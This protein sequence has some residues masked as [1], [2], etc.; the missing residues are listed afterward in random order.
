MPHIR[1]YHDTTDRSQVIRLWRELLG[2][3]VPHRQPELSIDNKLACA[4]GLFFVAEAQGQVIATAMAGYD[5][6]RGWLY[7]VAVDPAFQRQ[8]LGQQ[9]VAVAEQALTALGCVKINLQ[10][11]SSN[12]ATAAFYEALGYEVEPII[13][14]GKIIPANLAGPKST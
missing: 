5:G 11:L 1:P 14:M 4:D 12:Q 2:Y 9:L 13:S 8:G 7:A 3:N 6:H 10:V